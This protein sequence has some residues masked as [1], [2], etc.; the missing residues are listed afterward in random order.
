MQTAGRERERLSETAPIRNKNNVWLKTYARKRWTSSTA[1]RVPQGTVWPQRRPTHPKPAR[2][3]ESHPKQRTANVNIQEVT[4]HH[5]DVLDVDLDL[6]GDV[7][8]P[9]VRNGVRGREREAA[10]GQT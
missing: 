9:P 2:K 3:Q 4:A 10:T 5:A 7:A 6:R 8:H 1:G